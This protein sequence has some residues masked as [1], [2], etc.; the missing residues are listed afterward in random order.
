MKKATVNGRGASA[1]NGN[2]FRNVLRASASVV[3]MGGLLA[4]N[5]AYAQDAD[6]G[7]IPDSQQDNAN[8]IVV[9]GIRQSLENAQNI[10]RDADTVVDA[11]TAEDI[12]A[13]PD[14]S[15]TEALQRVPGVAI[16][17][18]AGSNDP[19]HFSVEG[20]GVVADGSLQQDGTF[21]AT[22]LLAKHDENYVPRELEGLEGHKT[23]DYASE[24]TVGLE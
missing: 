15:V 19:D 3:A 6:E 16:N 14:R 12:G 23:A 8:E 13:L 2:L 17:R 24:T 7:D 11:I 22:N 5:A 20:S 10:K 21:L 18:F 4:A 1:T 9:S